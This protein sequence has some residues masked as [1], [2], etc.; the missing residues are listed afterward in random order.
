MTLLDTR[1]HY[2]PMNY[3]WA[4]E[5]YK[6]Q[7]QMHWLPEEVPLRDDITDWNK[8]LS[9]SEKNLLTQLF[10][11]FTQGDIAVAEGYLH[12]YIPIFAHQPELSMMLSSFA[13]MEAIHIDSY[14][15]L[16]DTVG[17]PE[18]EYQAFREYSAMKA[19]Y[20][21]LDNTNMLCYTD[22]NRADGAIS[23]EGIES[24][25]K[26]LA[27]YSAFTEGLQLFSS[28]AILLNFPRHNK[29]KGMGQI[30][31]FSIRD[32]SLHI[33]SM[34]KLFHTLVQEFPYIWTDELKQSLYQACKDMVDLEDKFI[35]LVFEQGDLE[36]LTKEEV[37]QY[38]RY[39][40]DRRLLQLGLKTNYK[41]K[42]NPL[43]WIDSTLNGLEHVN[44]FE[45]RA[46]EYSRGVITG[47]DRIE[48]W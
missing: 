25:A 18:V 10:R 4:Y 3:P 19:K 15:L 24:L 12:K 46:T 28:F 17:M 47:W 43:P 35:D 34:I 11:F 48:K 7:Q 26:G 33:E 38:I 37:K 27:I 6:Q 5:A 21:Y 40:A 8:N 32:E 42:V 1:S 36:G 2:K 16:L 44:F 20:D 23:V 9:S 45:Q 14:S 41:V 29:M 31:T 22:Y 30:V 39:I 13:N